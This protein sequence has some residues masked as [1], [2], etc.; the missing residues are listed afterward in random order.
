M[1]L[2]KGVLGAKVLVKT[3]IG[4]VVLMAVV[5]ITA[6]LVRTYAPQASTTSP[7]PSCSPQ[8]GAIV[9][10]SSPATQAAPSLPAMPENC[11]AT[12]EVL[13]LN[14]RTAEKLGG[15]RVTFG[16]QP[17]GVTQTDGTLTY[18][19]PQRSGPL[20]GDK[21]GFGGDLRWV[22]VE[23]GRTT[24]V[25]L[26]LE[27]KE[28]GTVYG[29]L[30]D[31]STGAT[32]NGSTV[33]LHR[34][35]PDG[36]KVFIAT[37][38]TAGKGTYSFPPQVFEDGKK[39]SLTP[40]ANN[41]YQ[42]KPKFFDSESTTFTYSLT[43]SGSVETNFHFERVS[44]SVVFMFKDADN[45]QNETLANLELCFNYPNT[46]RN[47]DFGLATANAPDCK[48]LAKSREYYEQTMLTADL[49][50]SLGK[51]SAYDIVQVQTQYTTGPNFQEKRNVVDP[52]VGRISALTRQ[53]IEND[54]GRYWVYVFVRKRA[55]VKPEP[56]ERP[57]PRRERQDV[58]L[59][60]YGPTTPSPVAGYEFE[61]SVNGSAFAVVSGTVAPLAQANED[62][63][64]VQKAHAQSTGAKQW[65]KA[66]IPVTTGF[67]GT[68]EYRIRSYVQTGATKTYSDYSPTASI[69]FPAPLP[70]IELFAADRVS[71]VQGLS[72]RLSWETNNVSSV[73]LMTPGSPN[74]NLGAGGVRTISPTQTTTYTLLVWRAG[75]SYTKQVT[76]EV[77][78]RPVTQPAMPQSLSASNDGTNVIRLQWNRVNNATGYYVYRAIDAA[79][80]DER[81]DAA[82]EIIAERGQMLNTVVYTDTL[83][84]LDKNEYVYWVRAVKAEAN[85]VGVSSPSSG[86]TVTANVVPPATP[87][88]FAASAMSGRR[89][90]LAWKAN[91]SNV[92]PT[93][94]GGF[95]IWRKGPTDADF[96]LLE[97]VPNASS[98]SYQWVDANLP[99]KTRFEYKAKAYRTIRGEKVYSPFSAPDGARS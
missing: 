5:G 34:V 24:R 40:H 12:L 88:K 23:E 38:D 96:T 78:P 67:V 29:I 10:S 45:E 32:I 26:L 27:P 4:L 76:V 18:R 72:A 31:Y 37:A 28:Q 49:R 59:R 89:I 64:L 41:Y 73:V 6:Y 1:A 57:V 98:V 30:R 21:Y 56:A 39:Y 90:K 14:R 84:P 77:L 44:M 48:V 63:G 74:T 25:T 47:S 16:G 3:W 2:K 52:L 81:N 22:I 68:M 17:I 11:N 53:D 62:A 42:A 80:V 20:A 58:T 43:S 19:L 65:Y 83:N 79:G 94:T 35:N 75:A 60:F 97:D 70:P 82:A 93:Y 92:V 55:V 7:T 36:T 46:E 51:N 69:N 15:V 33:D 91:P 61:Q 13:T 8:S 50:V 85:G 87:Y 66:T 86:K 9:T 99:A 54:Q 71:I 95:E